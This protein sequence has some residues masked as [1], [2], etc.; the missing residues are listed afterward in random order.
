MG[1][2]VT[3]GAETVYR[4]LD[5]EIT[6]RLTNF[7]EKMELIH[8]GSNTYKRIFHLLVAV[9]AIYLSAIYIFY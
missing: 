7:E 2:I 6:A 9:G 5:G 8:E 1:E 3:Q 4:Q